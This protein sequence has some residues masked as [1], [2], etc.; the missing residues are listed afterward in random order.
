VKPLHAWLLLLLLLLAERVCNYVVEAV[1]DGGRRLAEPVR[2]VLSLSWAL[3]SF[4]AAAAAAA[5]DDESICSRVKRSLTTVSLAR[6]AGTAQSHQQQ[7][8]QQ[9]MREMTGHL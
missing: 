1:D 9:L 5:D 8:Q 6:P 3:L 7:Q 2:G 4:P